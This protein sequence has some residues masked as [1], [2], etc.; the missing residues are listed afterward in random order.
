MRNPILLFALIA[1]VTLSSLSPLATWHTATALAQAPGRAVQAAQPIAPDACEPDGDADLRWIGQDYTWSDGHILSNGSTWSATTAL[2]Q[3]PGRVV[4]AERPP[5]PD[6]YEPDDDVEPPWIGQG[7]SQNHSFYP[8]GDVD[9]ARFRVK[10]GRWYEVYTSGLG[11]LVD[12]SLSIEVASILHKND[13]DGP[14]P[15]ASRIL[16]QAPADAEA[17]ITIINRQEVYGSEQVYKL[18]AGET[19]AP[20]PAPSR[21]PAATATPAKPIVNFVVQPEQTQKPGECVT[22]RWSVDRASEVFLVY[23]NGN[24]VGV[25]GEGEAQDCPQTSS[26]YTLK[27]N[28]PAGDET[29]EARVTVPLPTQTPT[30]TPQPTRSPSGSSKPKPKGKATLH[31]VVFVDHRNGSGPAGLDKYTTQNASDIYDPNE[32]VESATVLLM[33][34]ADPTRVQA[35]QTDS[36][37][38]VHFLQVPAGAYTVQIPHLGYAEAVNFRGEELAIDVPVPALRLPSRIP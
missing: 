8:E 36:L 11:S 27:V 4:Q 37:G 7:E 38:Q 33:S 34:Q 3:A 6:A 29:A 32:G 14:E 2:A 9:K 35:Q 10:A 26:T 5:E 17:T 13:D 20:T 19:A 18:Y 1:I 15:L 28:S 22:L 23:P 21:Q 31:V 24:Q 16:F 25:S 12:T 30:P